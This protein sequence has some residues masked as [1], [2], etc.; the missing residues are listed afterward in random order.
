MESST[1]THRYRPDIDGL[2]ALAII[3][4]ILYHAKLG[5]CGGYVGVDIFFVISGFL[6]SSLI[7]KEVA[8]GTFTFSGF[9]ERRARRIFPPLLVVVIAAMAA[10]W[11]F[12]DPVNFKIL[13]QSAVAQAT[14]LSNLLFYRLSRYGSGYFSTTLDLRA[15]LHTWSL[16]VEEQFYVL[17]PLLLLLLARFRNSVRSQ[18]LLSLAIVSFVLSVLGSY[19]CRSVAFYLLPTRAWELLLGTLLSLQQNKFSLSP[20]KR[21]TLGWI[22]L[23]LILFPITFYTDATRFPGLAALVPCLGTALIIFS[24]DSKLPTVGRLLASK[25]FVAVGL[26]SYS[27]YLWHWP[28]LVFA[29][30]VAYHLFSQ[31]TALRAAVLVVSAVIAFLSWKFVESP[32]RKRRIVPN[33]KQMLGFAACASVGLAMVSLVIVMNNGFP[34]RIQN[35][36]FLRYLD[37]RN[38]HAFRDPALTDAAITGHFANLGRGKPDAPIEFAV[39]GD[40]HAMAIASAF[41]ELGH[42]SSKRGILAAFH[43]TPPI[44]DYVSEDQVGI[45]AFGLKNK[46]PEVEDRVIKFIADNKIKHIILA[47]RWNAYSPS[48]KFK[49]QLLA[50]VH[51]A[52]ETGAKVYLLKEVPEPRFDTPRVAAYTALIHG[53][54]DKLGVTRQDYQERVRGFDTLFEEIAQMGATVL[55][56]SPYFLN[57]NGLFSAVRDGQVYYFDDSHLTIEGAR[58]L[59]P[60][61]EPIVTDKP[62]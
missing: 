28:L 30:A 8:A 21:E 34:S 17:F 12:L 5:C 55:D 42:Q 20:I 16:S 51:A 48:E 1:Q 11:F 59:K 31:G 47:A 60:L 23:A 7:I 29:N 56:P 44:L 18:V 43:G 41:D 9:M 49:K 37:S 24:G 54:L 27:L 3:P 13:G 52:L 39:W 26:V 53:D 38:H 15:L 46:A 10:G 22:G 58:L 62:K 57:Q 25:P 61:F 14:G 40:S 35:N 36:T 4:V 2:R 6:I 45:Q 50:T 33:R 32:F 19:Y